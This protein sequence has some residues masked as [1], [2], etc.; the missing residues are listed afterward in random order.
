MEYIQS[1]ETR[2]FRLTVT[3]S[4]SDK[5]PP[6]PKDPVSVKIYGNSDD[7]LR[8]CASKEALAMIPKDAASRGLP[9]II[10]TYE[11][12]IPAARHMGY[13]STQE[14]A[15]RLKARSATVPAITPPP[16]YKPDPLNLANSADSKDSK[17]LSKSD[18][19]NKI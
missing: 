1:V 3:P 15:D 19:N 8:F 17:R 6:D 9:T 5:I 13:L 18:P 4:V 12:M 14:V 2:N 7:G 16:T 11:S 10:R